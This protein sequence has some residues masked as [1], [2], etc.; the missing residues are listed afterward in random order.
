VPAKNVGELIELA[1]RERGKLNFAQGGL[2]NRIL[3]EQFRLQADLEFTFVPYK[4]SNPAT[5]AVV[6]GES[7]L[8]IT[9]SATVSPHIASGKL[10]ALAVTTPKRT[11]LMPDVPTAGEAGVPQYAVTV[12]YG[13]FAPGGTPPA[14]VRRLNAEF[15]RIVTTPDVAT[16]FTALG[17]EPVATTPEAFA[18]LVRSQMATVKDVATRAKIPME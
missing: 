2:T 3:G 16:R 4:G 13:I 6:S 11:S 10:R 7:D 9:D 8:T 12:W 1:R 17:A 14:V 15:N 18:A 5:I